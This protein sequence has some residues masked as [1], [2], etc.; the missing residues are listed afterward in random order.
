MM[1]L[2]GI[3]MLNNSKL[4]VSVLFIEMQHKLQKLEA[5]NALALKVD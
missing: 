2:Y 5:G 3:G 4:I 1:I